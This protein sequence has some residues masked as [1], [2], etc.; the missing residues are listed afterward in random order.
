V[1]NIFTLKVSTDFMH[2]RLKPEILW[3]F[4]DDNQGRVSPK[5]NYELSDNLWLTFGIHHF[6]GHE[7][8]SNGQFRNQKQIYASL[9]YTF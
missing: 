8:D 4:T 9:K 7:Q 3:S 1:E 2:E 5:V 6:Y